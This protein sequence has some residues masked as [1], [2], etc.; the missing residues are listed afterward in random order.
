MVLFIMEIVPISLGKIFKCLI[1]NRPKTSISALFEIRK[2]AENTF[3]SQQNG[4]S[5]E[6][7]A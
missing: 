2:R 1:K 5:M 4:D 7:F 3:P 6:Q